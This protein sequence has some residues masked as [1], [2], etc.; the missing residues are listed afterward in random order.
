MSSSETYLQ[1]K[2]ANQQTICLFNSEKSWGG[3]EKWHMDVAS[4]L[5][6]SG[7]QGILYCFPRKSPRK[8]DG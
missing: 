8:K 1:M 4:H 5:V 7:I 2:R 6:D 3:G